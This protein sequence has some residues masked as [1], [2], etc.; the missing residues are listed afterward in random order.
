MLKEHMQKD[1]ILP[2]GFKITTDY[3]AKEMTEFM[4]ASEED[5]ESSV[6][7]KLIYDKVYDLLKANDR[8]EVIANPIELSFSCKI[9]KE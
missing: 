3:I 7:S 1:T 6:S 4:L 5:G 2:S 9:I 8:L